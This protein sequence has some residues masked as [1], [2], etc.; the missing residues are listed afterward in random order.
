MRQPKQLLP[1][2]NKP[3]IA[4][5]LDTILA[6]GLKDVIVVLGAHR[7]KMG[8]SIAN[9]PVTIVF[10]NNPESEMA[11]SVLIGLQSVRIS[12]TGIMIC[13][14]DHPVVSLRTLKAVME[15]Y[16]EDPS[17]LIIPLFHNRRGHPTLFPKELLCGLTQGK[18][19]RDIINDNP[20]RVRYF[21]SQDE[22][23]VLDMDTPE[24]YRKI[25]EREAKTHRDP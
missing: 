23:V 8:T 3:A 25:I 4:H 19:L 18:T 16:D 22:G 9:Y 20:A 13:L 21:D 11:E 12:S 1:I 24:D 5:C 6:S 2:G 7:N 10:N 17:R 15:L 14:V